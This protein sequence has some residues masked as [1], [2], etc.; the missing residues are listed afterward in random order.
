MSIIGYL[1]VGVIALG[2]L[3]V[4]GALV[5]IILDIDKDDY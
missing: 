4:V 3:V 5:S 2:F 1:G